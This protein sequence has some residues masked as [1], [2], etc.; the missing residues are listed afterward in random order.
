MRTELREFLFLPSPAVLL[1]Y[2][3]L[4]DTDGRPLGEWRAPRELHEA[5]RWED[6]PSS[7]RGSRQGTVINVAALRQALRHWP[8]VIANLALLRDRFVE[9]AGVDEIDVAHLWL[10]GNIA[11][12]WP[13]FE[14]RRADRALA[15]D[16]IP[17]DLSAL[18]KVVQGL[19]LTAQHLAVSGTPL[20]QI[21]E[22]ARLLDYTESNRLLVLPGERACPAPVN[23][24]RQFFDVVL[25][26]H[27][28]PTGDDQ[29]EALSRST[30]DRL[31]DYAATTIEMQL[32]GVSYRIAAVR[33]FDRAT[34][35]LEDLHA[36]PSRPF[37]TTIAEVSA[38]WSVGS[39]PPITPEISARIESIVT[40]LMTI[41]RSSRL[42]AADAPA[43]ALLVHRDPPPE[44]V[45][46]HRDHLVRTIEQG[47]AP[48]GIQVLAPLCAESAMTSELAAAELTVLQLRAEE[49]LG[50]PLGPQI[51]VADLE[52]IYP[53]TLPACI[54]ATSSGSSTDSLAR[55]GDP[56]VI[57]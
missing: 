19:F 45:E 38:Q 41:N 51:R 27:S 55:S 37:V 25:H 23:L 49:V 42:Q 11:A 8:K 5:T 33:Q 7:Y 26:G 1:A 34:E 13:A 44:M 10:I 3:N 47:D 32:I 56:G 53:K 35:L 17:P 30:A 28:E 39:L 21:I 12:S 2:N 18:F 6:K 46:V 50:L 24:L 22:P 36:P 29:P 52:S 14:V 31:F 40:H 54:H 57:T 48:A 43:S 20:D 9:R 15:P 16:A 4:T